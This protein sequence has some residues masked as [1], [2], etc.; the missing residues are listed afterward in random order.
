MPL[1]QWVEANIIDPLTSGNHSLLRRAADVI[2]DQRLMQ[3]LTS[4]PDSIQLTPLQSYV[5]SA[6][7]DKSE[8]EDVV[9]TLKAITDENAQIELETLLR[10]PQ[11]LFIAESEWVSAEE[12]VRQEKAR[13]PTL[14][15]GVHDFKESTPEALSDQLAH[16]ANVFGVTTVEQVEIVQHALSTGAEALLDMDEHIR[17]KSEDV[18]MDTDDAGTEDEEDPRMKKLR[19]NLLAIAKRAPIDKI[20]QLPASLVPPHIRHIVPTLPS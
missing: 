8:M 10:D 20:A 13:L 18:P 17:Q 9:N 6:I 14:A 15:A 1:P 5:R 11:E 7:E 12:S 19:L 4:A 2:V 16:R 3:W